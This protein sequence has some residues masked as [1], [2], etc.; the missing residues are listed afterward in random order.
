MFKEKKR[1]VLVSRLLVAILAVALVFTLTPLSDKSI[2]YA[3]DSGLEVQT[4]VMV[5]TGQELLGSGYSASTVSN[6]RSYSLNELKQ[7]ETVTG[8][9]YS[10][11]KSDNSGTRNRVYVCADGVTIES[12]MNASGSSLENVQGDLVVTTGSYACTFNQ[13]VEYNNDGKAKTKKP[14]LAAYNNYYDGFSLEKRTEVP[15]ILSWAFND[16]TQEGGGIP[17]QY[18]DPPTQ[19]NPYL[20]LIVGQHGPVGNDGGPDDMNYPLYNG[21][22]GDAPNQII[23]GGAVEEKVLTVGSKDYTRSEVLLMDFADT[24]Y[25]YSTD[26]AT[27][28]DYVRGVPMSV[29]LN[30]YNNNDIVTFEAADGYPVDATGSTVKQLI[31]D[32]YILAYEQGNSADNV[33]GIYETAKKDNTKYGFFRLYGRNNGK[34]AKLINKISVQSASGTDFSTSPYKHITNGGQEGSSPYNI[35]AITGATL[36]VEGPGVKTSVPVSVR[37]LEG[38]DAGAVRATYTDKREGSDVSRTYEGIDLHYI[39]T[40]M[41][42]GDNGI[43]MT[44][45]AKRVLIKNRNRRTIA[46]FTVEQ[47]EEAHGTDTP[48]IVAYGTSLTDGTN[49][50]PFVF[51]NAAGADPDLGNEDGCIKLVY[52]KNSITGDAN[53]DYKTFGNMAYIYVAEEETPG[54]KH[55]KDP[56]QSPDISNYVV[57]VTGDKIG[58]EVNFTVGQLEN[59]VAYG[60]DGKPDN[61][62]MGYRD[63]YSLANSNYWYVNEYEGVQLWKLLLKSGLNPELADDDQ[64]L[65]SSTAT[66]GYPSTD[67]FTIKQVADPNSFG[68]YEKNPADPNTAG[69]SDENNE[70]MRDADHPKGDLIARGYPVLIAYGI[71]GYPYVEKASQAGYLSG[72]QNDGG[73]VRVISGKLRYG[74]PN[75]S[76]Q[77]KYLDK[78]IVGDNTNHYSTHKYHSDDVYTALAD[79]EVTVKI[80]NGADEDAPV[81]KEQ[82]YKVGD[83]EDLIYGGSLTTNQLK[84]AKVKNFYGI[85]KNGNVYS[86]LYEGI[87]L[88]YF[89]R[90]VVELPGYK[91]TITFGNGTSQLSLNLG[92]VLA[93]K[94][95]TNAKTGMSGLTPVLAYGK[96]GAPLVVGKNAAEGYQDSVTLAGGTDYEY[97][98]DVKNNGGPLSVM[99]PHTDNDLSEK[100]LSNVTSITINLSAD[101]YAHTK[102]PYNAYADYAVTIK[103]EGTRLGAEGKDF[104]LSELEGKQTIAFTGDYSTLKNG[105]TEATQARYRGIN[106]YSLLTSS[107]VGLKSNADKVIVTT[108][109]NRTKEFTLS[110]IRKSDYINS[111]TGDNDLPVILAYG[112]GKA[113][114]EDKEDGKP[115]VAETTDEGY[116]EEYGNAGGPIRLVVGQTDAEDVN[117]GK[118]IKAVK[119]IEVTAS[120]MTSWNHNSSEVY[121]QYRDEQV[122]LVVND[123]DG[124]ELFSRTYTVGEI[125]DN[126]D[127]VERT[128]ATVVQEFTWEGINFWR[129]VKQEVGN[130]ADLTD[131]ASVTVT[132]AD[133]FSQEIRG[134][135]GTDGLENGIKDGENRVPI[136]LAYGVGGYP[137]VIGDKSHANGEGYDATAQNNGGPLR[138]VTHNSQGTSLTYVTK[139]TVA[140][141]GG[142]TQPEEPADFTIKGLEGGD[143]KMSVDDIKNLKNKAGDNIGQAEGEYVVSGETKT[144]KGALLKNILAAKG[145]E[146]E[147]AVITLNT[148]DGFEQFDKG[149]SYR[150]ITLKQAIEQNYFLAYQEKIGDEWVDIDDTVKGTDIHTNLRMYRNYCAANDLSNLEKWYDE[151]KNITAV[152]LDVPESV[153]F[154]EYGTSGGVRSTWMDGD[155]TIWVGTYGGGLY[156]K[157]AGESE[158][159]VMNTSSVPVALQTDFTSAVAADADGGIWVSQNA[160]YTNP[161]NNQGVLY[162]KGSEVTQYTVESNPGTIPNNY[163]QAIKVDTDGKVWMGS[164]GGLT[165]YDPD[166]GTWT[167]YSKAD[168]DFPAT[169]INTITLDGKGG[170]WLGFYPDGSGT[171]ADPY[172]GGF[173]HI[174]SDGTVDK[175]VPAGGVGDTLFAQSWVRSIAIDQKGTVWAVAAGTNIPNVGGV[176]WKWKSDNDEP[177]RYEGS[178][179]LGDYLDDEKAEVRVVS[180]DKDGSLWFG[181]SADGILKVDNPKPNAD[182]TMNVTAQ[183][184]KE[185]GSWSAANMNNVYSI[186]FWN[187]GTAYVGTAGG[188]VVLGNE[189][190]GGQGDDPAVDATVQ[191]VE[192]LIDALPNADDITVDDADAILAARDA[193]EALSDAEKAKVTNADKLT[194]ALDALD[195]VVRGGFVEKGESLIEKI[196]FSDYSAANG[197]G[198]WVKLN[199]LESK[200]ANAETAEEAAEIYHQIEDAI[201]GVKT[202]KQTALENLNEFPVVVTAKS[203]GYNKV[204]LSWN[205]RTSARSYTVYRATKPNGTFKKLKMI[206]DL[207]FIDK[208][209]KTGTTYY[210][211][212]VP[213][214]KVKGEYVYGNPSEAVAGKPILSKTKVTLKAGKKKVT[215]KWKK[216]A[217]AS[218]YV[219]YRSVKKGSGFKAVKTIK[220]GKTVSFVNKNLKGKKT[221]YYKVK[222]YR[223]VGGKKVYSGFSA[224]KGVKTKKK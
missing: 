22:Y 149:A 137:L 53:A 73:P 122:Q 62:G 87:D 29:L 37:D 59:M 102:A 152:T 88:N 113:G 97:S 187:D 103:G 150:D 49:V 132:A 157:K 204:K 164:F 71:N 21:K 223:L 154:K 209:L 189:P 136:L 76:N 84:E 115:L 193:Y 33:Q 117:S 65:V 111:I 26:G 138:L 124:N 72:L 147:N 18:P 107:A 131:P 119:S 179:I 91:G 66:D 45:K 181:T 199:R 77:A 197:F 207:S 98:Y 32:D 17:E 162:I 1:R 120:E 5:V 211:A 75:G 79:N 54:Y 160:S 96:N 156:S 135:F 180:V 177:S 44:D 151:C 145:V 178:T 186:D 64:T 34:P 38:R 182:G 219:I 81:L 7:M 94:N 161:G 105:A 80:L 221:Y 155:G 126:T 214:A 142:G 140:A 52:D 195:N 191:Q 2:S 67:K 82:T 27:V 4:P 198:L 167:T 175:V 128:A 201:A 99:F 85:T 15:P 169:S 130:A 43:K 68:F 47:I 202:L 224:V 158:F 20:R 11:R 205:K 123:N 51:D 118:N 144:V 217:G 165:I 92:D 25:S 58:R 6:E 89:L 10:A 93:T 143:I 206:Q 35:D 146:N 14:A 23:V 108:T 110:E 153:K 78:I 139:I 24:S 114:D 174:T 95:G 36:T 129:W 104:T 28:T 141:G 216:V 57:T 31:D 215:V 112:A 106:L 172:A 40:K 192:A 30:G 90:N 69:W 63:E 12:L 41:G 74:H 116:V 83:I 46:E 222:A 127:L 101:N 56:Y 125:E 203:A 19:D 109:D 121:K 184:A 188:L 200:L 8:Q 134:K 3:T 190:A 100:N 159:S 212:V 39:L 168:K 86:D 208:N 70:V 210:Y 148:P 176:I 9:M 61:N 196:D 60:D 213:G 55:D 170:A 16:Y 218:G 42:N 173:C 48:I 163:V 185:T 171:E 50:R 166:A 133:G 13:S 183:Y 220:K 194:D